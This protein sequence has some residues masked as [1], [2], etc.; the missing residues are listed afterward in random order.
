MYTLEIKRKCGETW[1]LIV[2]KDG[3]VFKFWSFCRLIEALE[4]ASTL[5]IHVSNADELPLNQYYK[6]I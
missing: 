3:Q 6:C 4:M 2:S 5:Q 1:F